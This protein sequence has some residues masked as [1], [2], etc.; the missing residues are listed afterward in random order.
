MP[1]SG[2]SMDRYLAATTDS[3]E[4]TEKNA[5]RRADAVV[6]RTAELV[7][8]LESAARGFGIDPAALDLPRA[9][10]AAEATKVAMHERAR[11]YYEAQVR[12]RAAGTAP[13]DAMAAAMAAP[14][15]DATTALVAADALDDAD[16][17]AG[18]ELRAAF[19]EAPALAGAAAGD[20]VYDLP[21]ED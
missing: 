9:A 19:D 10:A 18:A 12:L 20:D 3:P 7:A 11:A 15:A 1:G 17:G 8:D 6:T 5:R 16:Y 21:T 14:D 4:Q 13:G 2:E